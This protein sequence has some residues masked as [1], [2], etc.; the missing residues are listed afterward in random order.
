METGIVTQDEWRDGIGNIRIGIEN[1]EP[2]IFRITPRPL[3]ND[4]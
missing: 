4:S 1:A 2:E 3:L